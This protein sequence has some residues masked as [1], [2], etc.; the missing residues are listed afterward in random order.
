MLFPLAVTAVFLLGFE[1][2]GFQLALIHVADTFKLNHSMAGFMVTAHYAAISIMPL[3]FGRI[4]DRIGKKPILIVFSSIMMLGC[5]VAVFSKASGVF[6]LGII[7]IGAGYGISECFYTAA[8]SDSDPVNAEKKINLMQAAFCFGAFISPMIISYLMS[9][10]AAWRIVFILAG[11]SIAAI[12]PVLLLTRFHAAQQSSEA[13][14][15]PMRLRDLFTSKV[16]L[17]LFLLIIAFA[18]LECGIAYFTVSFMTIELGSPT[19][20]AYSL[21]CFWLA[22]M[23]SRLAFS[24]ITVSSLRIINILFACTSAVLFTLVFSHNHILALLLFIM[25][26]IFIGPIW[27]VIVATGTKTFPNDSGTVASILMAGSGGGASL[28]PYL[29]GLFADA[30]G[31][32]YSFGFL[33]L[34]SLLASL[35]WFG[36]KKFSSNHL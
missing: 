11:L 32:R 12:F 27:P 1:S 7:M 18:G 8:V 33:A 5:L 17:V 3:I 16:L 6:I 2:G 31:F 25:A 21:S 4:S 28:F 23:V 15:K 14:L 19:F 9:R 10:G 22:M 34:I 26:G 36:S 20:G 29:L 24:R 30:F 35:L 13:A